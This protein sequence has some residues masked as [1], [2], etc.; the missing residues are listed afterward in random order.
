MV[1]QEEIQSIYKSVICFSLQPIPCKGW[2]VCILFREKEKEIDPNF[3]SKSI[4]DAAVVFALS[5]V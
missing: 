5:K 3:G 2:P 4:W 1:L